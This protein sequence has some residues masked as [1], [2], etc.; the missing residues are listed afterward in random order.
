METI[1][2]QFERHWPALSDLNSVRVEEKCTYGDIL[3]SLA[4]IYEESY[5]SLLQIQ[6][7]ETGQDLL[8]FELNDLLNGGRTL[9]PKKLQVRAGIRKWSAL[10][11]MGDTVFRRGL[12]ETIHPI[13]LDMGRPCRHAQ[14][15]IKGHSILVCPL[16]LL[17][18]MLIANSCRL[19]LLNPVG[20]TPSV[21]ILAEKSGT[22]GYKW[23]LSGSPFQCQIPVE[24]GQADRAC[25]KSR[26][27]QVI[28][29]NKLQKIIPTTVSASLQQIISAMIHRPHTAS[30]DLES[31]IQKGWIC[32]GEI[33]THQAD[34]SKEK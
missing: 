12:G 32:F 21:K 30:C 29:S 25:W 2:H 22:N 6:R 11:E 31:K 24:E 17:T 33:E 13:D 34:K 8:R 4:G 9:C 23:V 14:S 15:P 27:Q 3:W 16:Y 18:E 7:T 10:V 19:Q 28:P 1:Q 26:L 20:Q 5:S